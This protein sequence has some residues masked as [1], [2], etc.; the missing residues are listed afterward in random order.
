[1]TDLRAR[2]VEQIRPDGAPLTGALADAFAAVPREVF[3]PDGF[4][5]RDGGW[6]VP[7]D[8]DFLDLVYRDDVLVTKVDGR[9]PI[10]SSS[11]PSLMA[12]MLQALDVRPGVRILEIGA[13]TGY[14]AALMSALGATVTSVDVQPDVAARADA[15]VQA[16]GC[17]G[18]RVQTGDGYRG[19]PGQ[20]DRVIVTVGVSG[21]SPFWFAR[22]TGA[23]PVVAPVAHAGTHPV[24][25]LP[26]M[27]TASVVCA[28]AFMSAAGPLMASHPLGHPAPAPPGALRGFTPAAPARWNPPLDA[29]AYHDLWY[30]AGVWHRRATQAALPDYGDGVLALLGRG[31]A[32]AAVLT[33]GAVLAGGRQAAD[34]TADAVQVMDRWET[35]GRPAMR[36]WQIELARAGFP[37]APIWVPTRWRL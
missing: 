9:V 13:G 17:S 10:S 14:N 25:A 29:V 5:R 33:D 15:A 19:A 20:F 30:A 11:Q 2:Y 16:A 26:D 7:G 23:G 18:V 6:A 35:A 27:T 12:A 8:A 36:A 3:V 1:M 37:K 32:G 22:L 21:V 28:A 24:L 4:R 31:G 34:L